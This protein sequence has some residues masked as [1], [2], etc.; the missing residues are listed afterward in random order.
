MDGEF[1]P[2]TET[3]DIPGDENAGQRRQM[4]IALKAEQAL[5]NA[6][7]QWPGCKTKL[8]GAVR[9]AEGLCRS[10][11]PMVM[12][13]QYHD[14]LKDEMK[15]ATEMKLEL[16]KLKEAEGARAPGLMYNEFIVYD[17]A[18]IEMKYVVVFDMDFSIELD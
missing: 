16:V 15:S 7:A 17:T 8:Q 2:D 13:K 12:L 1:E 5:E 10:T 14:D 11:L 18:Q 3:E 4:H 6:K 9:R